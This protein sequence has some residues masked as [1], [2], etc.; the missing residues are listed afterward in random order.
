MSVWKV[1][2][3]GSRAGRKRL[4]ELEARGESI[5]DPAVVAKV[6][7]IAEGIRRRGDKALLAAV[8]RYDGVSARRVSGLRLDPSR[9]PKEKLAAGFELAFERAIAAVERYH[10]HQ[11]REGSR[12]ESSGVELI[13]RRLPL[14]RVGIYVPGGRAAYP[15]TVAMTVIPA[16]MAGV[17]EIVVVTPPKSLETS[18]ALRHALKRLGVDEV[19]GL[20]GAH[21]VAALAYGTATIP[22]VDKIVGPGN[23]WVTAAKHLVSSKVA[24]DGLAG[25]SE[26][27]I[28]ATG[29][30]NPMWIAA[31]LLAQAEHDPEATALLMTDNKSLA[32][33]VGKEVTRQLRDLPTAKVARKSLA[34]RGGALLVENMEE[35]LT[36]AERLAPEHLQLVGKGA[37]ELAARVTRSGAVFVG[38]TTPEVFGDYIAGPSHVLPTGGTARHASALGVEDF[39][40]R[41]HQIRF[42][43]YAAARSAEAAAEL[44]SCEGLPAH[45]RSARLRGQA[46]G[47]EL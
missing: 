11:V 22:A 30:A 16:R 5:L 20:G 26:V 37:E 12:L 29:E 38:E 27:L 14:A 39:V 10:R 33:A 17:G 24:I 28:V 1:K 9:A 2:K 32:Q 45:A 34:K 35:A 3:T 13:E 31:D 47:G 8:R 4:A 21:A 7:G 36:I 25:P 23:A 6:A 42:S 40:R 43:R 18:P 41:S 15:S 19:W 46:G 44:A